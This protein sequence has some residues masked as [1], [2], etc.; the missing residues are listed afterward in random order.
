MKPAKPRPD[1][2][3]RHGQRPAKVE[4]SVGPHAV[5]KSLAMRA[6]EEWEERRKGIL[7]NPPGAKAIT[8]RELIRGSEGAQAEGREAPASK[9]ISLAKARADFGAVLRLARQF[10]SVKIVH[11]SRLVGVFTTAAALAPEHP[12]GYFAAAYARSGS[13][14]VAAR[15]RVNKRAAALWAKQRGK[16]QASYVGAAR[17]LFTGRLVSPEPIAPEDW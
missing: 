13:G 16:Q 10:G 7:L 9:A 17:H 3:A 14:S 8:I 5:K 12:P 15:R 1:A 11:G 2:T 6:T 4:A